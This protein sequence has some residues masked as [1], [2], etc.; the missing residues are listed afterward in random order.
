MVTS[1]EISVRNMKYDK[2]SSD[3]QDVTITDICLQRAL[4]STSH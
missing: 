4:Q 1:T 3:W 2:D